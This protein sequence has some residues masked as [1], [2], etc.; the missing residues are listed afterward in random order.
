MHRLRRFIQALVNLSGA[1]YTFA[2]FGLLLLHWFGRDHRW[3]LAFLVNFMPFYFVPLVV[4]I[5]VALSVRAYF[6]LVV[7]APLALIGLVL[8]GPLFLPKATGTVS[9]SSLTL[10]TFN[11]S[12]T[13]Q[14][15]DSVIAWLRQQHADVVLLQEVPMGWFVPFQQALGD[16]YPYQVEQLTDKGIRGNLTLSHF[17]LRLNPDTGGTPGF[18]SALLN[19]GSRSITIYNVSLLTPVNSDPSLHVSFAGWFLDLLEHYSDTLRNLQIAH[20][21][22]QTDAETGAYIV[23]GDFNMSDQTSIYTRLTQHMEDTFR[24]AGIGLGTSWPAFQVVGLGALPPLIRIDYIW[25]SREFRALSAEV[26]PYLGSDHLPVEATLNLN[27]LS[28]AAG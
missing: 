8:Y 22:S 9:G 2:L 24:E 11:V 13:N 18:R 25:H 15:Q 1:S 17:P 3:W 26:G 12:D 21:L 20:L 6:A 5:V 10:I 7:A 4:L 28:A 23:A 19:L 27:P 16:L 14:H